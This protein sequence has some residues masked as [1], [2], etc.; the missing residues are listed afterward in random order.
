LYNAKQGGE[1]YGNIDVSYNRIETSGAG[2]GITFNDKNTDIDLPLYIY[3]NN[4]IGN[5]RFI[6]VAADTPNIILKDNAIESYDAE[7]FSCEGCSDESS[8]ITQG[9]QFSAEKGSFFR[10]RDETVGAISKDTFSS[11]VGADIVYELNQPKNLEPRLET[12]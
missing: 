3:R 10:D 6:K 7:V 4:I 1:S 2:F 11:S 12:N 5:V 9:N 8:V